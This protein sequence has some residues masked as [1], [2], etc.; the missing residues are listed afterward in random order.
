MLEWAAQG[1]GGA[2][3]PRCCTKGRSLVGKHWWWVDGWTQW[4]WRSLPTLVILWLYDLWVHVLLKMGVQ[5]RGV[6]RE[7]SIKRNIFQFVVRVFATFPSAFHWWF[8]ESNQ[9]KIAVLVYL[10]VEGKNPSFHY[11][12][13]LHITFSPF[14][15]AFKARLDGALRSW[16]W[17]VALPTAQGGSWLGFEVPLNP[18][19]FV[20]LWIFH[21]SL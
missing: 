11:H 8:T 16:I 19:C 5:T 21:Y 1:G 2:P 10:R 17:W 4:F 20:I 3:V 13:A 6:N 15:E 7:V 12:N 14:L 18:S 9:D